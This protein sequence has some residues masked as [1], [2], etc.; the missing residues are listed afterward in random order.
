VD[1]A[2]LSPDE[3]IKYETN[4]IRISMIAIDPFKMKLVFFLFALDVARELPL[5]LFKI[6]T[7]PKMRI[8][9]F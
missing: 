7:L 2:L 1:A 4:A 5:K 6:T 3:K 9:T 8:S